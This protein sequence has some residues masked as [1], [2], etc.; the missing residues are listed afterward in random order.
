MVLKF[1]MLKFQNTRFDDVDSLAVA[2][3]WQ[4]IASA[5]ADHESA[6]AFFGESLARRP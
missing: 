1:M 2:M 5:G 4:R 6:P 3:R